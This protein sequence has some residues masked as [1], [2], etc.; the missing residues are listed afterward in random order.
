MDNDVLA[1]VID[2][3]RE[4]EIADREAEIVD[5]EAET[6]GEVAKDIEESDL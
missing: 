6:R 1:V 2:A 3:D 5:R 4:V